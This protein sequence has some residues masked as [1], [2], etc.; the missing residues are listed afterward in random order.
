MGTASSTLRIDP[1]TCYLR[2]KRSLRIPSY[3]APY[4]V[5]TRRISTIKSSTTRSIIVIAGAA[6][7]TGLLV[8]SPENPREKIDHAYAAA[9]RTGRV[10]TTLTS[11]IN[12]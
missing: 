2:L 1:G 12:E 4:S 3:T 9:Q 11:C 8:F 7:G 10:L 5:K 6:L